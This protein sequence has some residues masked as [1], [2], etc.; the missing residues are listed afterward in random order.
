MKILTTLIG[1]LLLLPAASAAADGDK[2]AVLQLGPARLIALADAQGEFNLNNVLTPAYVEQGKALAPDGK[3]KSYVNAY[4]LQMDGR[5]IL[6]DTG[7]G[8]EKGGQLLNALAEVNVKPEAIDIILITHLH[9][10]HAGGLYNQGQEVFSKAV[11]WVA[12]EEAR[13]WR[14]TENLPAGQQGSADAARQ[15]LKAANQIGGAHV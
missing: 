4:L 12:E 9:L 14:D 6:I 1:L 5:N 2:T 10:D 13:F 15:A 7:L 11:L 8:A 3:M